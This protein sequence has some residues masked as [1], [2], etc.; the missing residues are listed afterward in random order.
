M[1]R[2]NIILLVILLV[3]VGIQLVR[4]N[5]NNPL[6]DP[7]ADFITL[8]NPP[9]EVKVLLK[10][11]CYDCHSHLTVY[12]WYTNVAPFSWIIGKHINEGRKHLNFSTW[13]DYKKDKQRHKIEECVEEV[14][15]GH[16]PIPNY[17]WMHPEAKM[18]E[19][20]REKMVAWLHS[21]M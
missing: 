4:I 12:P 8:E 10:N 3:I 11:A 14:K 2:K 21:K 13:G 5:K 19:E 18:S 16:M 7:E 20:D 9:E 17:T 15:E 6:S 1:K